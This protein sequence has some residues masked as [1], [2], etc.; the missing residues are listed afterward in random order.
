MKKEV[1]EPI[2][3]KWIWIVLLV[4][5]L[6][7]V[8]WYLPKGTIYPI[9]LGFPFW[10][11]ISFVSA[12]GLSIFLNYVISNCWDMEGAFIENEVKEEELNG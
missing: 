2:K 6:I 7:S 10:T 1:K 12:V 5:S 4:I 11:F 9:V 3:I 8:P